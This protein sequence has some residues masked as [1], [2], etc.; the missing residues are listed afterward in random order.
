M[1]TNYS[2]LILILDRSGSMSSIKDKMNEGIASF[3]KEQSEQPGECTISIFHFNEKTDNV[4][5]FKDIKDK[6][7]FDRVFIEPAGMTALNDA[8][9]QVFKS[10]GTKLA[11]MNELERPSKVMVTIVT[12]GFE[13]SSR[14]YSS[15]DIRD[16]IEHQRT[17]YSWLIDFMGCNEDA[18]VNV[19]VYN[20][21]H[22]FK[23]CGDARVDWSKISNT[24]RTMR[25][26]DQVTYNAVVIN[27]GNIY[28]END[29]NDNK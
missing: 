5:S 19:D 4:F 21:N 7:I 23:S 16:M 28:Q 12:D 14:E 17:K 15:K 20:L 18:M 22:N 29:A 1:N 9:G 24:R 13:N 8:V 27:H 25:S 26:L 11:A 6:S 10:E 3:L 2:H